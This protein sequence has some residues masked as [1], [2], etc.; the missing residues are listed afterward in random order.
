MTADRYPIPPT[1]M[2]GK[3]CLEHRLF[4][5]NRCLVNEVERLKEIMGTVANILGGPVAPMTA[6]VRSQERAERI[7][8]AVAIIAK[9]V[10]EKEARV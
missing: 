6:E 4:M 2:D 9:V 1:L 3:T 7:D 5:C 10:G 8:S